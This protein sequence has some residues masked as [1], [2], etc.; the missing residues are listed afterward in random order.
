MEPR[1]SSLAALR[2]KLVSAINRGELLRTSRDLLADKEITAQK[3]QAAILKRSIATCERIVSETNAVKTQILEAFKQ[4]GIAQSPATAQKGQYAQFHSLDLAVA[5]KNLKAAMQQLKKTGFGVDQVLIDRADQ[6][7]AYGSEL[8]AMKQGAWSV[9][10]NLKW[11]TRTKAQ[12]KFSAS[13]VDV[14]Y[15]N[16]PGI[17]GIFYPLVGTIRKIHDLV[18]GQRTEDRLKL[19]AASHN[20][21]TPEALIDGL[22]AQLDLNTDDVVFDLGCADGRVLLSA[23]KRYGCQCVGIERNRSLVEQARDLVVRADLESKISIIEG[24]IE[25]AEL[26][27]ASVIFLFLPPKMLNRVLNDIRPRLQLGTR[28]IAHEQLPIR[29]DWQPDLVEPVLAK[30]ALTVA[31]VWRVQGS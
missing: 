10:A 23:A 20:L 22:F 19:L 2:A 31:Y 25:E 28:I 11:R 9:R 4:A 17:L 16:L 26:N 24:D 8:V 27:K 29:T 14:A 1:K 6:L 5:P 18:V 13:P 21:G 15:V 30:N 7:A 12:R 3:S